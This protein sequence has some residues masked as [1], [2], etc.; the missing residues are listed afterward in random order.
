MNDNFLMLC[1]Y[2]TLL[3]SN[4]PEAVAVYESGS[5]LSGVDEC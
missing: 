3:V 2:L 4:F 5:K 1:I